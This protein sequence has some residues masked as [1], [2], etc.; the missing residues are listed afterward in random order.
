MYWY[1]LFLFF[2]VGNEIREGLLCEWNRSVIDLGVEE[3]KI[4]N[5]Y[6]FVIVFKYGFFI[7]FKNRGKKKIY[8]FKICYLMEIIEFN[9]Y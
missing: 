1:F 6:F 5:L 2:I 8:F 4:V 7:F 3:E 9:I